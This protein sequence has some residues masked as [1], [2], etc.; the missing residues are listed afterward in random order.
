MQKPPKGGFC[1]SGALPGA[2][3]ASWHRACFK[4]GNCVEYQLLCLFYFFQREQ[5]DPVRGN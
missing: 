3:M 2:T 5:M 4:Y 1:F